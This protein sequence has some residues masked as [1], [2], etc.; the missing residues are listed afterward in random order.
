MFHFFA[1]TP[2]AREALKMQLRFGVMVGVMIFRMLASEALSKALVNPSLVVGVKSNRDGV[3]GVGRKFSSL[4]KN[5]SIRWV[6][7]GE[8]KRQWRFKV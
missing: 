5:G 7:L 4:I 6:A 2:E 3:S 1:T 8:V